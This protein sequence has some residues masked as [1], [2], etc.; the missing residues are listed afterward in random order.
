M[1]AAN[2][3]RISL[4]TLAGVATL[5]MID[6]RADTRVGVSLGFRLPNGHAEIQVGKDRFYTHRGVFYRHDPHRGYMVV[7]APRGAHL[8]SLPPRAIRVYVGSSVYYRYDDTY[9]QSAPDGYVIVAAPPAVVKP[10]TAVEEE[11]QS[12]W[13]DSTEYL[14][15]DGQ[16]FRKTPDGLVWIEAPQGALT[17]SLPA[18]AKSIWYAGNEYYETDD[19]YFRKTPDGYMVVTAPWKK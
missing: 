5:A 13:L 16:F 6:L 8:R 7:R 19:V 15:K 1:N 4:M 11:Y 2:A 3:L 10:A 18:D 17:K 14:F 12:V 9:Y